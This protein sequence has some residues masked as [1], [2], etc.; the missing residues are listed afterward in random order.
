MP[1]THGDDLDAVRAHRD[2]LHVVALGEPRRRRAGGRVREAAIRSGRAPARTSRGRV[3]GDRRDRRRWRT[4]W[5]RP[6]SATAP[7]VSP[8]SRRPERDVDGEVGAA[9]AVGIDLGELAGAVERVDD[10]DPVRGEP[11]GVVLRPPRTGRRR[12]GRQSA[13]AAAS[14]ACA[15]ASPARAEALAVERQVARRRPD[16]GAPTRTWPAPAARAA[17]R[18]ASSARSAAGT[19]GASARSLVTKARLPSSAAV[20]F[21]ASRSSSARATCVPRAAGA[22]RARTPSGSRAAG[23]TL[24]SAHASHRFGPSPGLPAVTPTCHARPRRRRARPPRA[25]PRR[26]RSRRRAVPAGRRRRT[27]ASS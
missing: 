13:S 19:T 11:R 12:P 7:A 18:R 14:Q 9:R 8:R 10:P 26:A 23:A 6:G 3:V 1:S 4:I 22:A 17:A 15:C 5:P 25:R 21:V 2:E 24:S 20:S 16:R 27:T